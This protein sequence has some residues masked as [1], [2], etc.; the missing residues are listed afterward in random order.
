MDQTPRGEPIGCLALL[1]GLAALALVAS[2]TSP[3]RRLASTVWPA[4]AESP[5][6][7]G[8]SDVA[9]GGASGSLAAE[10]E[11]LREEARRVRE[12]RM[13]ARKERMAAI[14]GGYGE[15]GR[16]QYRRI[17]LRNTCRYAI[18]VALHYR[19]LDDSPV[20]RG[21]WEVAPGGSLTTDAMTRDAS[22]FL[23]A[24]NQRVGRTWDGEGQAD[25]LALPISDEKFDLVDG[26]PLLFRAPRTVSFAKRATGTEWTDALE[27]FECP[28]E[29]APPK[30]A[31]A[32]PPSSAGQGPRQR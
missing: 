26:E 22:F 5:P 11:S 10:I 24:E 4:P 7:A 18:A 28:V 14:A 2:T 12:E 25:A 16:R 13:T 32:R 29:E 19:D 31:V 8:A 20:T 23:Y 27:T 9:G 3:G 1:V 15:G 6:S 21:W 30:G 17:A